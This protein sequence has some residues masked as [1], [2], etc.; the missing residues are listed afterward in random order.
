MSHEL[1]TPLNGVLGYAELMRL[2]GGLSVS[3]TGRLDAMVGAGTHLLHMI[4]RVLSLSQIEAEKATLDL[5]KCDLRGLVETCLDL[6]R[7]AADAKKLR[8]GLFVARDVPHSVVI[9]VVRLRQ[10]LLNL[11]GNA[12]K[13]TDQ[14]SIELCVRL[15]PHRD[16][17]RIE[18]LDTGPGIPAGQHDRLFQEF[19]RLDAGDMSTVEGAG[20][21]LAI[22]ARL[23]AVMGGHIGHEDNPPGGSVFWLELPLEAGL[24]SAS[25][26]RADVPAIDAPNPSPIPAPARSLRVLVVDDV[27]MN[28][29]IT[30]SFLRASGHKVSYAE[31]GIEAV[32]A[33]D[34]ADFD[35]V[36]MDIRMPGVDGMEATRRIHLLKGTRGQVPIVALTALAFPEQLEQCRQAGMIDHVVKP[37]TFETLNNVVEHA[38]QQ[39]RGGSEVGQAG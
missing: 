28:R 5:A 13:Y 1:R 23:A 33:V 25:P 10:V 20:L 15:S 19:E 12:V 7:P 3:Q 36:L 27:A 31:G 8:L 22:S 37:F 26:R 17:L 29:D 6:V 4:N 21:G 39:A 18:V 35:V 14:G 9:D 30:G 11:L 32:A 34:A 16:R 38:A 24:R 2:E